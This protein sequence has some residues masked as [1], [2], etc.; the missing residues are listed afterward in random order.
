MVACAAI[1]AL[2]FSFT[3]CVKPA[4]AD[5]ASAA[6]SPTSSY[7]LPDLKGRTI[8]AAADSTRPPLNFVDPKTG[9]P[10]G[11]EYDAVREIGRR[12]NAK[13]EWKLSSGDL[14]IQSVRDGL[15]DVGMGGITISDERRSQFDF[16][17]P[18]MVSKQYM[19]LGTE[20]FGFIFKKGSDLVA[21]FNTV[22][23]ALK[24]DGTLEKLNAKWFL[25]YKP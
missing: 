4:R 22:I 25:E 23:A 13:I 7:G 11:W 14:M 2:A 19:P 8:V 20:E 9:K 24:A 21:P 1:T 16:S 12:L 17:D 5:A 10:V 15:F 3:C 18:C 6:T